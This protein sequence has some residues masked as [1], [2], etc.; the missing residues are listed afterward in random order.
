M[1]VSCSNGLAPGDVVRRRWPYLV[2]EWKIQF[3]GVFPLLN[4]ADAALDGKND[5]VSSQSAFSTKGLII[6]RFFKSQQIW[7]RDFQFC[8]SG[9]FIPDPGSRIRFFSIPDPGF[10]IQIF[11]SWIPDPGSKFF[12]SWILDLGSTSKKLSIL[13]KKNDFSALR[14][15]IRVFHLGSG[16]RIWILT[17]YPYRILILY[18]RS[19]IQGSK[20]HRS[21]DPG[22]R[23]RICN[24]R[25]F[26][27]AQVVGGTVGYWPSTGAA[28]LK[29]HLMDQLLEA[30]MCEKEFSVYFISTL[31]L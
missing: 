10:W 9:M 27:F 29:T 4:A 12:P 16:S 3:T 22:S 20:R 28:V 11:P 5:L 8:W 21:P 17:F 19:R 14:N 25:D 31:S 23:I 30:F 7:R 2:G 24:T 26:G 6:T 1:K 18:P 15:M 13:T